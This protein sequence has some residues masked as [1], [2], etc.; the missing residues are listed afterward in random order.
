MKRVGSFLVVLLLFILLSAYLVAA[1]SP[2]SDTNTQAR[3]YQSY[4]GTWLSSRNAESEEAVH[5]KGG[6]ILQILEIKDNYI[7]GSV[8]SL[9]SPPASR[10]STLEFEGALVNDVVRFNYIDSWGG[11]EGEGVLTI[12]DDAIEVVLNLLPSEKK[13]LW[14]VKGGLFI[15]PKQ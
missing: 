8:Y 5:K 11:I 10:I 15:R 2:S 14:R 6:E 4:L 12:K 7:K 13:Y 1:K 9:Q 3:N